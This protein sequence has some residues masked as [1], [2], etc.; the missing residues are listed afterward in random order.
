FLG[1]TFT[2]DAQRAELADD[3]R[4]TWIAEL[5]DGTPVGY[6]QLRRGTRADGVNAEQPAEVQ[7]IY[8]DRDAHGRRVGQA[9]MD[10][11]IEEARAWRC[12]VLWLAVWEHNPRAIAFYKKMGFERVGS[13][14]FLLGTDLQR[15]HV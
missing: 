12:D 14:T 5:A 4:K 11:C 10:A 9:L 2:A 6:A 3:E 15:D 7:R 1:R 8:V 13:T